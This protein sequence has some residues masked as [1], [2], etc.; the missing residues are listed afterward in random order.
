MENHHDVYLFFLL[1]Y[2]SSSGLA[3]SLKAVSGCIFI[4][5]GK[6][7]LALEG[8]FVTGVHLLPLCLENA[9]LWG[10][11]RSFAASAR[12]ISPVPWQPARR[13]LQR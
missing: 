12:H 8:D 4:S 13:H 3:A 1:K 9:D 6:R 7:S 11:L 10:A 5:R 2:F